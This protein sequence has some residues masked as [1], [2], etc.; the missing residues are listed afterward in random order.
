M[1]RPI[2]VA[3]PPL[4]TTHFSIRQHVC[5]RHKDSHEPLTAHA[6]RLGHLPAAVRCQP[7]VTPARRRAGGPDPED[8]CAHAQHFDHCGCLWLDLRRWLPDKSAIASLV[9]SAKYRASWVFYR[10]PR[11]PRIARVDR[12]R[13]IAAD[14]TLPPGQALV[15]AL[16][17]RR[18]IMLLWRQIGSRDDG[19]ATAGHATPGQVRG[20]KT[21]PS[22]RGGATDGAART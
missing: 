7:D 1:R 16:S 19:E 4:V 2:V 21:F 11:R 12:R 5:R 22:P 6:R 14:R 17:S 18:R 20:P 3:Q 10:C 13:G 8:S 15:G 9:L